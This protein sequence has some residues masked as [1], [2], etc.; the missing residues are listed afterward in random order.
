MSM[1]HRR[2]W[3]GMYVGCDYSTFESMSTPEVWDAVPTSGKLQIILIIGQ[4]EA[5]SEGWSWPLW[6][7]KFGWEPQ[8]K[9]LEKNG[10]KHYMRGGK[11]GYFPTFDGMWLPLNL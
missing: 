8:F 6:M 11:P 2:C 5:W 1:T 10:A 9:S 4:L 3:F 7:S